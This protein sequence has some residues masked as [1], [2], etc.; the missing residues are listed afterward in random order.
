MV[1]GASTYALVK[2]VVLGHSSAGYAILADDGW[3]YR[4]REMDCEGLKLIWWTIDVVDRRIVL[5]LKG[6]G[7]EKQRR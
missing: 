7:G 6:S 1:G 3:K 5:L 4:G 2:S